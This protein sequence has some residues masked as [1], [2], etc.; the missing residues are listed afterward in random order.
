MAGDGDNRPAKPFAI[1]KARKQIPY[2]GVARAVQTASADGG[3]YESPLEI[4]VDVPGSASVA[5]VAAG[6][7]EARD[8]TRV[9]SEVGGAGETRHITNFAGGPGQMD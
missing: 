1:K 6:R 8:Q 4:G 2:V 9:T 5:G 3:F 7:D